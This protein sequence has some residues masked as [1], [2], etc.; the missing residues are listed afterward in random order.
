MY[1][2]IDQ[3]V[4]RLCNGGRFLLWAMRGWTQALSPGFRSAGAL[5]ALPHFH[6][7]MAWL[8]RGAHEPVAFAPMGC[9][10]IAEDE[11]ILLGLWHALA[12]GD[13]DRVRATL[14]LIAD[15]GA[16]SQIMQAMTAAMAQIIAAGFDLSDP[17]R[18]TLK[19][20][21]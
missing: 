6:L 17:S 8:N 1:A 9:V 21:K 13:M 12:M 15:K 4:D 7:A 19:E 5:A 16:I 10:I 18:V 20:T 14:E 3:P 11:A 2:Y